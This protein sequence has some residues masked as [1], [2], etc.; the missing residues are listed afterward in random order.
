VHEHCGDDI[1]LV[2][3]VW[4][5]RY[6]KQE[7]EPYSDGRA[8]RQISLAF[9]REGENPP[10]ANWRPLLNALSQRQDDRGG[11]RFQLLLAPLPNIDGGKIRKSECPR[12]TGATRPQDE[13]AAAPWHDPETLERI[14]SERVPAAAVAGN[15]R[16]DPRKPGMKA[17]ST[18]VRR[19]SG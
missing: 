18:E 14:R 10:A 15:V 7:G 2:G 19:K 8:H 3:R 5:T 12:T 11:V 6:V 17:S 1:R 9:R 16:C 4:G 13:G